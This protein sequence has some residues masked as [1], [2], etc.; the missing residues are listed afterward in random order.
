MPR[1]WVS[2]Q[3]AVRGSRCGG[4]VR[5]AW[6]ARASWRGRDAKPDAHAMT[7]EAAWRVRAHLPSYLVCGTIDVDGVVGK[8]TIGVHGLF[9]L[10]RCVENLTH[11]WWLLSDRIQNTVINEARVV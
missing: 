9:R 3:R 8:L 10:L 5:G 6:A 2:T 11:V 1:V 4:H 7:H